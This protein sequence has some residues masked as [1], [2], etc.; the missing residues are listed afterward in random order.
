MEEIS[1]TYQSSLQGHSKC[2]LSG[3]LAASWKII[4]MT[5]IMLSV[6]QLH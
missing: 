1:F 3:R 2:W 6:S 4:R 5:G